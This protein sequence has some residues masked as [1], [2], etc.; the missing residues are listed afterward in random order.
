M[1]S[2]VSSVYLP[3]DPC[4]FAGLY[5]PSPLCLCPQYISLFKSFYD[6]VCFIQVK[7]VV[8]LPSLQAGSSSM[9]LTLP[10]PGSHMVYTAQDITANSMQFK[11]QFRTFDKDR[12]LIW[13]EMNRGGN[14][15]LR[16]SPEGYIEYEMIP[17]AETNAFPIKEIA[18]SSM[19][20]CLPNSFAQ[21]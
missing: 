13:N 10:E 16:V 17:T 6:Y 8:V 11:L 9:P 4:V 18:K 1:V 3:V 12:L 5:S 15:F 7:Y 14:F 19:Y 2:F 21:I 20:Y